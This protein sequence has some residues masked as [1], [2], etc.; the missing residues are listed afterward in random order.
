MQSIWFIFSVFYVWTSEKKNV[1]HTEKAK[2]HEVV[3]K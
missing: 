2:V 1:L 3:K